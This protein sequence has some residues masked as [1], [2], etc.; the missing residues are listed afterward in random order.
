[1][2]MDKPP[3]YAVRCSQKTARKKARNESNISMKKYHHRPTLGVRSDSV[4]WMPYVRERKSHELPV[5]AK[6]MP[7]RRLR[8]IVVMAMH[9]AAKVATLA[10]R[11]FSGCRS[12]E[13]RMSGGR[14]RIGYMDR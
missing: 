8:Q 2:R 3:T 4:S 5:R 1:M 9:F 7:R 12:K 10:V 11:R 14:S 6:D 13:R